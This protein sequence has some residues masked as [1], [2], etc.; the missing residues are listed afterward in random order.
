MSCQHGN[1]IENKLIIDSGPRVLFEDMI[2][3]YIII[4]MIFFATADST[5]LSTSQSWELWWSIEV[6]SKSIWSWTETVLLKLMTPCVGVHCI[7]C[8]MLI[9]CSPSPYVYFPFG[10]G[11]RS[12]MGRVFA[13]VSCIRLYTHRLHFTVLNPTCK[14]MEAKVVM[15]HL[16]RTYN[17]SLPT[18]YCLK[19]DAEAVT[20]QPVGGLP[21]TLTLRE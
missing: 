18:N 12:C 4:C 7:V 10:I 3:D 1:F 17:L 21:C 20:M 8:C 2:S 6:W 13:M 9:Y 15:V 16:L 19:L 14:Q 5:I 11:H